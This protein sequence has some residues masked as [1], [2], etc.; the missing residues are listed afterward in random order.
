MTHEELEKLFLKLSD[1]HRRAGVMRIWPSEDWQKAFNIYNEGHPEDRPLHQGCK[2]CY[3]KVL[4]YLKHIIR[5]I[6]NQDTIQN[7]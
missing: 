6:I 2:P 5:P 4:M 3:I 7:D 1:E